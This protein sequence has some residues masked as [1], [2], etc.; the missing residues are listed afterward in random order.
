MKFP[1]VNKRRPY[2]KSLAGRRRVK[3]L[4]LLLDLLAGLFDIFAEA[5]GGVAAR[6]REDASD[7]ENEES[8]FRSVV[9]GRLA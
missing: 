1:G 8:V 4:G 6:E 7:E 5:V 2:I 3:L 9:H